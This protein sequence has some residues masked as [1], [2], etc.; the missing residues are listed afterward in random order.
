MKQTGYLFILLMTMLLVVGCSQK[1]ADEIDFGTVNNSVYK[2]EYFGLSIT[3][4]PD[5]SIQDQE[6][7]QKLKELGGQMVAGDDENLK[8]A[9]KASELT[10]VNLFTAFKH[11]IGTPVE[12]NPS[13]TSLAER[14]RHIPGIKT[15]KD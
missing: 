9:V 6:T 15:G 3:L 4:P 14:V 5:W 13:I 10:T 12:Y 11:P 1:A 7:R 8:A 2:N